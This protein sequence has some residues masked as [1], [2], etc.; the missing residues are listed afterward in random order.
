MEEKTHNTE[1]PSLDDLLNKN[2]ILKPDIELRSE[3]VQEIMS[4][5]P[6]WILRR[7]I[8]TLFL[9]VMILL[10]GSWFFKYPDTITAEITV[11]SLEPPA[12]IIARSTGKIDKIYVLNK[13]E[14]VS[15]TPLAV[16]QNPANSD[17]MLFL[18]QMMNEWNRVGYS[19]EIAH[20]FFTGKPL[21]LGAIQTAFASFLNS[22]N[23]YQNYKT[24][25]YYP[26]K[27]VS[28]KQQL[29]TQREYYSRIAKQT[30]VVNE[31]FHTSK[32]IFERDSILLSKKVISG[33]EYDLSKNNYLQAK[34][35]YLA[36]NASL[37]QSELQLMQGEEN[38]L[39]LQQQ[40][41][42]LE[43]KYQLSLQNAAEALNAQIKAWERDFLLVSPING[44][45]TQMGVWSNN[46]NV[47]ASETIFTVVPL[48]QKTPKGKAMLP[49]QGAGKVK[50]GQRVNVRIN[51]FPD[52]EFGYLIGKVESISSVPTAEGLYVVGI[53]FP[54]GMQT[55]YNKILPITQQMLGSADII[56]DDLRLLERLF[57][58]VKKM[59][60]NQQN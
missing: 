39:D 59:I 18:M 28:Q 34:Q 24:L 33:N 30:P 42:E 20:D 8:T 32:S 21:A 44:V 26:Q 55:N 5:I 46:Q 51:N 17:D 36:F 37:K 40:A 50:T 47:N 48:Q 58:P 22:L 10:I 45:V 60:R 52:Q 29:I 15:G 13:Q 9:I 3:E 27:I 11:T 41:T 6:P 2:I 7:G 54:N 19:E 1:I 43:R 12:S 53:D 14:V 49:A 25:N 31:L 23:D 16:I 56:T 57:M 38:L 35:S 4:Q